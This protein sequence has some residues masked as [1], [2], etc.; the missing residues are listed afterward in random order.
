MLSGLALTTS[1]LGNVFAQ[2]KPNV[3]LIM[4]DDLG[5]SDV[6]FNGNT[7]IK[8]PNLDRMASE[9]VKFTRFYAASAVCSP[10]RASVL[11]GR[12][13]S[14]SGVFYANEGILRREEVTLPEIVKEEGY[15]T[16]HF[17]K[18]HLG[19]MTHTEVDANRGR[20]G[21]TAEYN[22]PKWHGYDEAFVTESK[23]PT[24]DPMRKPVTGATREGWD[25]LKPDQHSKIYGT[26]YWDING[27]RV[28]ANLNGDD[29]RVIMD[30]VLP[31]IDKAK[32]DD[33]P[34][35][36]VVWFHTPHLP[37]VAGPEYQ[38]MYKDQDPLMRN[39]AGCI[40]AMDDQIGRL[41]K[42]LQKLGISK[43][44]MIWFCSDNGPEIG[45]PGEAGIFQGRKRSFH[46]GGIR[47]PGVFVWP[48]KIKQ[49]MVT[50]VPC[51][52]SD[53]LPTILDMLQLDK[54][55]ELHQLDGVSLL[56]LLEGKSSFKRSPIGFAIREQIAF[57]NSRYKLYAREGEFELY[58][59]LS[60]PEE[61][62]NIASKK[63]NLVKRK[64]K[65]Y[66]RWLASCR[67]S[68][69]GDEY[70]VE[71]YEKLPQKW[72]NPLVAKSRK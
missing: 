26:A 9:G 64:A 34:F 52:T 24:Y 51:V 31:F 21:N 55:K 41:R 43:N 10:T 28:T 35:L 71:S 30:R 56:P 46:E 67:A 11:T 14:R 27:K 7:I 48:Q 1:I 6:G 70:G 18:W 50:D 68:F 66:R 17:G 2:E 33:K 29:S 3:I 40:T 47:V 53:Y 58:D 57:V 38:D 49:P 63:K 61:K 59:I 20:P 15:S 4:A 22:P 25:Y 54:S 16:G 5:W 32:G 69:Q 37:C 12:N 42:H 23:V 13:P 36:A 65:E 19:T 8:T 44:T 39:Y 45:T 60:D 72:V 62:F